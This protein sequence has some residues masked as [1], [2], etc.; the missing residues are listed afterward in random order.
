MSKTDRIRVRFAPAPTGDLHVGGA[1]T[2]LFNWLFAIIYTGNTR[3]SY[4]IAAMRTIV[5]AV[6]MNWTRKEKKP[7]EKEDFSGT[8]A[9]A[10]ISAMLYAGVSKQKV[11]NRL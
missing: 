8:T 2:A 6:K 1:R 5:I 9:N 4:W 3:R 11:G 10:E 7:K